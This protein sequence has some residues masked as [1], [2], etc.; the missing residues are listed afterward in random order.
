MALGASQ[1]FHAAPVT[2]R[3]KENL[4][5]TSLTPEP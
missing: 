5:R 4:C 1:R 3:G 2:D